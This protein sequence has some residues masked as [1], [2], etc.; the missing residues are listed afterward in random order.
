MQ[1]KRFLKNHRCHDSFRWVVCNFTPCK[2][3][4]Q[5]EGFS[6]NLQGSLELAKDKSHSACSKEGVNFLFIEFCIAI[7]IT[8]YFHLIISFQVVSLY[9]LESSW[10]NMYMNIY[11]WLISIHVFL[12]V[13]IAFYTFLMLLLAS[14]KDGTFLLWTILTSHLHF[15][16][17]WWTQKVLCWQMLNIFLGGREETL[18][19]SICPFFGINTSIMI[20]FLLPAWNLLNSSLKKRWTKEYTPLIS[21]FLLVVERKTEYL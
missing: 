19:C 15:L 16:M 14:G 12:L 10:N 1:K 21:F 6:S 4:K 17:P 9:S 11:F 7:F 5:N 18:M 13:R 20:Y 3:C 8:I 2:E